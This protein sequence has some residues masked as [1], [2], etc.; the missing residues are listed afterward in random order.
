[1]TRTLLVTV[2]AGALF[3]L[4]GAYLR[5]PPW[6][7]QITSGL[8]DWELD[9]SDGTHYR[10]TTGRA[11]FFVPSDATA[12]TLPLRPVFPGPDG[13]AVT[14]SIAVDDRWLTDVELR[15]P[16]AWMRTSLP[17]PRRATRRRFRRVDLHVSR[18]LVG[19]FIIGVQTGEIELER[20]HPPR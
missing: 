20:P 18:T 1:M 2:V 10:W 17:L 4:G 19:P 5:D 14:V 15:Q 12:L 16:R 8:R 6:A 9:R 13:A 11:S 3:A 7:G